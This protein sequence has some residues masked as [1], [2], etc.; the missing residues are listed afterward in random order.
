MALGVLLV[1]DLEIFRAEANG[2]RSGEWSNKT[3]G[4][5]R[6]SRNRNEIEGS[7]FSEDT[8]IFS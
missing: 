5:N 1:V 3:A 6:S 2:G 8:K 7:R 4:R